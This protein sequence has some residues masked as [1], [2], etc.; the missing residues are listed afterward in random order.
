MLLNSIGW[1]TKFLKSLLSWLNLLML[2]EGWFLLYWWWFKRKMTIYHE[3]ILLCVDEILSCNWF[4]FGWIVKE[5]IESCFVVFVDD[6]YDMSCIEISKMVNF[7][8][9]P[10]MNTLGEGGYFVVWMLVNEDWWELMTECECGL[11]ICVE[12]ASV[13]YSPPLPNVWLY[14]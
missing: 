5:Y 14:V 7:L 11:L 9:W 1:I 3:F 12:I 8:L 13:I 10:K 6:V 4:P 2:V